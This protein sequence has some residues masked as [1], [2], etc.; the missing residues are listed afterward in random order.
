M[1]FLEHLATLLAGIATVTQFQRQPERFF[2]VS[3]FPWDLRMFPEG[4][5]LF[6]LKGNGNV[7]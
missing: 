2:T 4:S 1:I 7:S 6:N 5:A 3:P